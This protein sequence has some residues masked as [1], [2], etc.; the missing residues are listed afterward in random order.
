MLVVLSTELDPRS[1]ACAISSPTAQIARL[2]RPRP[3]GDNTDVPVMSRS[4]NTV[5]ALQQLMREL[6]TAYPEANGIAWLSAN[7]R[8]RPASN[9]EFRVLR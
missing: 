8:K 4:E 2:Q 5:P 6:P 3:G 9:D 7:A 1:R